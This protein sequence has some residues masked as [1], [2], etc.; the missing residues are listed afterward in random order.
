MICN[1]PSYHQAF[2]GV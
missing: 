2:V 1:Y